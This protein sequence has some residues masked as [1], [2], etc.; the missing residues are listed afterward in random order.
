MTTFALP[1]DFRF[2]HSTP[3]R[4]PHQNVVA[5]ATMTVTIVLRFISKSCVTT[6]AR[7]CCNMVVGLNPSFSHWDCDLSQDCLSWHNSTFPSP[8]PFQQTVPRGFPKSSPFCG[9]F[10][11]KA[12]K[13]DSLWT[14]MH[15]QSRATGDEHL[16]MCIAERDAGMGKGIPNCID[17]NYGSFDIHR[18]FKSLSI[19]LGHFG[20]TL[21]S[22]WHRFWVSL[23]SPWDHFGITLWSVYV[24]FGFILDL[25]WDHFGI[26]LA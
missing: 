23:G 17:I 1:T 18:T 3:Q 4:K 13:S 25:F 11:G 22:C 16:W 19:P 26:T 15:V 5:I 10:K 8:P 9:W 7:R 2:T 20:V 12:K 21:W 24:H 6:K 14:L